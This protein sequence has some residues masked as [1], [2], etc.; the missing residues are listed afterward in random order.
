MVDEMLTK[1]FSRTEMECP[2]CGVCEMKPEFMIKLQ[3]LRDSWNRPI[4][5]DSGFRCPSHN[6]IVGGEPD[7]QH[8]IGNAADIL[9]EDNEERF[10]LLVRI[11]SIGFRGIGANEKYTHV[12]LRVGNAVCWLYPISNSKA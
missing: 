6:K 9:I 8:L 12:D 4:I 7:S 3:Q 10:G 1:N 2:C 11:F 5:I